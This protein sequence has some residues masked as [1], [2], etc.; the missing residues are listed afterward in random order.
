MKM[1]TAEELEF[2]GAFEVHRIG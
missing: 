1:E 2:N